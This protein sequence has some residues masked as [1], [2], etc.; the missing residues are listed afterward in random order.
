MSRILRKTT[1]AALLILFTG[2]S[3]V[4]SSQQA[5]AISE[6]SLIVLTNNERATG[7][8][9]PLAWN[10]ALS[11]SARLKA[12]DMCN[13]GYWAH[14][15][16]DGSTPWTFMNK[17][18][19]DYIDAGENLA[20]GFGDD[21]AVLAGWMASPGHRAN[22]LSSK[23]HEIGTASTEC[24][25]NGVTTS[26]VVAH[27]GS[28]AT[29]PT[30]TPAPKAIPAPVTTSR[31][32]TALALK[33]AAATA[34]AET[35]KIDETSTLQPAKITEAK[36]ATKNNENFVSKLWKIFTIQLHGLRTISALNV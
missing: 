19:Y 4:F 27:Y 34:S 31:V 3:T 32:V 11:S 33:F 15:A 26:L 25:L 13:K 22:I 1:C 30:A 7:G 20:K 35:P 12:S 8:L 9:A 21:A 6:Q 5:Y 28:L 36:T 17:A 2:L 29:K 14:T 18:G 23:Y 24:D 10:A 16:P